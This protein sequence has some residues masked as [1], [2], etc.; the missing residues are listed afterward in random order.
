MKEVALEAPAEVSPAGSPVVTPQ[1]RSFHY[2][3]VLLLAE[4]LAAVPFEE[5]NE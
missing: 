4:L 1:Y 3:A 2:S 5:E